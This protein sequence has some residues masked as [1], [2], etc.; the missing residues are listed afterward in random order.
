MDSNTLHPFQWK[1]AVMVTRFLG[2]LAATVL[3]GALFAVPAVAA[4]PAAVD[5]SGT[6][7]LSNCSGSVVKPAAASQ[8]DLALVLSNG[9]CLQGGFLQPGQV[10]V[11]KASSRTF[12]LL[13]PD[14]QNTLGTLRASKVA[15]GT[16]TNTDIS[17]Y[18]LTTTYARI[19]S[20]YGIKALD[21]SASHPTAGTAIKVVSGYWKKIYS[22]G[23]DG[24]VHELHEGNWVWRD[25]IR[26]TEPGCEVIG[27][28]SGS[29][30]VEAATGKVIGINNTINENGQ[31]CTLNNPCE[32]DE[33]GN[34]KVVPNV[35]YG[36][37]TYLINSCVDTG[38][39]INLNKP[40]CTLPK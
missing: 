18:Q 16:M 19:Q 4:E 8:N 23:I 29:P 14:G 10:V 5:F 37:E 15:Y 30:V 3:G 25:S 40:G 28:T 26:Y 32:V 39:K 31:R 17:L 27:G 38:N 11:D 36:Q 7:K 20:R 6:V 35:G 12:S 1:G 22:C 13:S 9:H 33:N 24:F 2:A 21:L 34:V